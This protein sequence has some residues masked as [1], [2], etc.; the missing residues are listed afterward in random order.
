MK[1]RGIFP[2]FAA[3]M[4]LLTGEELHAAEAPVKVYILA[5]QSN[6][7]GIGQVSGGSRRWGDEFIDPVLS[8][9]EGD[10]D[11]SKDYDEMTP[12]RTVKLETFGGVSPQ[13]YPGGGTQIVRGQ[14]Q[15]KETGIYEFFPG[16]GD[17]RNAIMHVDG[18]EVWHQKPGELAVQ[19]SIKLDADK[20]VSFK[21]TYLTD[22][23][24]GLGWFGRVD[25]PGTLKTVVN[26]EGKFPYLID[27]KGRFAPRDDVWYK[28]VVTATAHQWLN[29]GCGANKE[30]IGPELGFG[31]MVG[32]FHD[33]PVLLLKTSQGNRSL[34]WD[35]LPPGSE[36][37]EHT[38]PDGT[39]YIYAG[40]KDRAGRWE[41]G[42]E[43]EESSWYG[44]K[45][46]DECFDAAKEV[47]ANFDEKFPHW[48]DRGYEIAGFCWWQGH[49]DGGEA[50]E[51]EA[52]AHAIRYEQNLARL[53]EVLREEFKAPNAPF[54]VATCGFNGGEG[55]EPG[56]SARTIWNAQMAVGDSDKHPK[57]AGNVASVD[58]RPFYRPP[59]QSP[60][61]QS[62]HYHGNAE[63]YM[64]VGEAMG[65]A[66]VEM[67]R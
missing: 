17:S 61:N 36:R 55:W 63:T 31:H 48:Q 22:K 35:F 66:M 37:F 45:Q 46:Y 23:A 67:K 49:K 16:L 62:F 38:E 56:S 29:V 6:M 41:K 30:S 19:K 8:V 34:G 13:K 4:V 10:Y 21:V 58:T 12:I 28:G 47:L 65:R 52:G 59:E 51:G 18:R 64:L 54:V 15:V 44:G 40:Y 25:I 50:G 39:T 1:A 24:D 43:P 20:E 27:E 11:P 60:R 14:L 42:T 7:V 5:G 3:A 32:N 26:I 57:L 9:Y 33:E 2:L 53:I